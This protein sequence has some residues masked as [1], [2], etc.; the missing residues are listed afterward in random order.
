MKM[1]SVCV[2][3]RVIVMFTIITKKHYFFIFELDSEDTESS[4][5]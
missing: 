1:V 2:I 3:L 5:F 4:E